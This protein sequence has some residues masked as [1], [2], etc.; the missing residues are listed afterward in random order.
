[1]TDQSP[2]DPEDAKILTLARAARARNAATDGAAVRDTT[3]RTYAA[4]PV[5]LPALKLSALQ[6]AVA[7]AVSSGATGLEAAAVVSGDAGTAGVLP[8]PDLAVARDLN[9][10]VIL[11]AG[12]DAAPPEWSGVLRLL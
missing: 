10:G 7:A 5:N 3:G 6:A 11:L 8:E 1:M 12:P 2:L 4:I 9:T